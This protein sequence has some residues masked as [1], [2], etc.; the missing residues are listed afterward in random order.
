VTAPVPPDLWDKIRALVRQ[1]MADY[2][3]SGPLRNAS[4]TSGETVIQGGRLRVLFPAAEGGRAAAYFG[5]I[6]NENDPDE[7]LG[8]G[9]MFQAPGGTDIASFRSDVENAGI[10]LA[11][12]RDAQGQIVFQTDREDGEGIARPYIPSTFYP[13][14]Y[15]DMTV[16]TT[17]AAFETLFEAVVYKQ[18]PQLVASARYTMDAAATTGEVRV[19]V[20][21]VQLGD[22]KTVGYAIGT[23]IFGPLPIAGEHMDPITV[24][25]QGRR[26]SATGALRVVPRYVIGREYV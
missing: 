20:G 3:R 24:Q 11:I 7:Y 13:A 14:R 19:L 10:P 21:G 15:A 2:T 23:G 17:A 12:I 5:D 18:H 16:S 4:I 25:I 1:E 6:Y 9:M 26:T 8:T 22:V